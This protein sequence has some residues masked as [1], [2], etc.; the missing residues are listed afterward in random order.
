ME[1]KPIKNIKDLGLDLSKVSNLEVEGIDSSTLVTALEERAKENQPKDFKRTKRSS[2]FNF[3]QPT[4]VNLPS[5]GR[6]YKTEDENIKKGKINMYPLTM[7][8]E[9]I[10]STP[11]YINDGTATI[12][13]LENC[14]D[15]D[16][17]ATDL[18][19]YDFTYLLFYLR[20]ISFGDEYNVTNICSNCG[21][22]FKSVIKISDIEFNTLP[23][24]FRDPYRI[25]LPVSKYTIIISMPRIRH[26]REFE[27]KYVSLTAKERESYSGISDMFS[28]R[29]S[30]I[31]DDKGDLVPKEDWIEFYT[32]IP[33]LDRVKLSEKASIESGINSIMNKVKCPNCDTVVGGAIPVTDDLF[34]FE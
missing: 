25:E 4:L 6:F 5:E 34:R 16:I 9:E 1:Q 13:A 30:A 20:K 2:K 7:R 11:M 10:L 3:T 19:V 33:A 8:E 24:D 14:I 31:L 26:V 23:K 29:T 18:L 28:I 22:R 17:S 32:S 15:S 12:K 21:H 27:D